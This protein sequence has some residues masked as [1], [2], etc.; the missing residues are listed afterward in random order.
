M[1]VFTG[2]LLFLTMTLSSQGKMRVKGEKNQTESLH[3]TS[4]STVPVSFDYSRCKYLR[5]AYFSFLISSFILSLNFY[6]IF[7]FRKKN[8]EHSQKKND[9]T[10]AICSR[11][12]DKLVHVY[13]DRSVTLH[14]TWVLGNKL[15]T[16]KMSFRKPLM[17]KRAK[18][19]YCAR[20]RSFR[21]LPHSKITKKSIGFHQA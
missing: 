17:P 3:R 15:H 16:T 12:C 18:E 9:T 21:K 19:I 1:A 5:L 4:L 13:M 11:S 8:Q 20:R 2:L 14:A 10:L 6:F 7:V